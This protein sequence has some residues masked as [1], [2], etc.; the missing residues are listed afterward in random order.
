MNYYF[1]I[2]GYESAG[3]VKAKSIEEAK[4]KVIMSQGNYS[5]ISLLDNED[6]DNYDVAVLI[7]E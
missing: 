4:H 5:S 2:N 6:F 7:I 1:W 3:V